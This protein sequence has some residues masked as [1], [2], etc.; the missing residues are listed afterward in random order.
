[1]KELIFNRFYFRGRVWQV[2]KELIFNSFSFGEGCG[3]HNTI[4][5]YDFSIFGG[6]CGSLERD[7]I[8]NSFLFMGRVCWS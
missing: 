7:L 6:G 8:C 1:M 2:L 5:F 4:D 3:S